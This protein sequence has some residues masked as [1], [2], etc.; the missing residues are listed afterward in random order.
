MLFEITTFIFYTLFCLLSVLGYGIIFSKILYNSSK[1]NLGELGLFGFLLLFFISLFL[2]F[3]IPL[4]YLLNLLI[5]SLGFLVSIIKYKYIKNQVAKIKTN[6]VILSLIILPSILIYKTHGDYDWY[7]LPYVNYLNNFKIVF[8]LVNVQNNYAHGHGWMDVMGMFSLPIVEAKG[9]SIIALIFFY[10][11]ILYLLFEI[12]DTKLKSVKI[13]SII[14]I[15]FCFATYNKLADFGTEIQ[16]ALIIFVLVLNVLKLLSENNKS[17]VL[18]KITLYFFY[19]IVLRM[20]SIIIIPFVLI[21]VLLNFNNLLKSIMNDLR[22]H[23]FLFL[24]FICFLIKSLILSGCLNYPLYKTCFGNDKI[25]WA[26]PIENAREHFEFL[27]AISHRWHFYLTEEA[28]LEK[29]EQYL[30][31]MN[32]GII[33]DPRSYNENK[34]FWLKYWSRDHDNAKLLNSILIILFCFICFS[35]FSKNKINIFYP[36]NFKPIQNN[37]IHVGLFFSILMWFFLSPSMRYGGYLVI[38]GTLT[39]YSSLIL[40]KYTINDKKFNYVAIF[41]LLIPTSYFVIKNITR[42]VNIISE[43]KFTN[44]PWP[45]NKHKTLG[46]DYKEI[47][48]NGVKLNLILTSENMVEGKNIGP[49][50]CSDVDM[51]CMP[52]ERIV[53]ISDINTKNGYIFIKNNKPEC[54]KQIKNNYWQ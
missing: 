41:L 21:V 46:I 29:R 17:E 36:L 44:F 40:S 6:F 12:K 25:P 22:L 34:L 26:S 49:V 24:F 42:V 53:C 20:G 54:L 1:K 50:M 45:E 19:A 10:Y 13:Y 7:Q 2:H 35:I 52:N 39:F 18:T 30:K 33:L 27:T 38:G 9:V 28:N 23:F 14:I 43:N 37:L 4:S 31:P 51:L 47:I 16:P 32:E 5:L 11:F 15:I 8:G 48:I 3:F